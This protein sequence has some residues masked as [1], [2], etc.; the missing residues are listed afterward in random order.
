MFFIRVDICPFYES[1]G[2]EFCYNP[3]CTLMV[4]DA[5]FKRSWLTD[6]LQTSGAAGGLDLKVY[7]AP[8]GGTSGFLNMTL[9]TSDA[10]LPDAPAAAGSAGSLDLDRPRLARLTQSTLG[11]ADDSGSGGAVVGTDIY[12]V[13]LGATTNLAV[14]AA[15]LGLYARV[16]LKVE[17][18]DS[19]ATTPQA[20]TDN[21]VSEADV[22]LGA[23]PGVLCAGLAAGT[24]AIRISGKQVGCAKIPGNTPTCA[25]TSK[26][27]ASTSI[28]FYIVTAFDNASD[29]ST[30]A[31]ASLATTSNAGST[32][33]NLPSC[34]ELS[35][36]ATTEN[37]DSGGCCGSLDDRGFGGPEKLQELTAR[38]LMFSP[39]LWFAIVWAF[40]RG[41][42]QIKKRARLK[43]A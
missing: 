40:V 10:D 28:P 33:K 37:S 23:D 35:T 5:A 39:L 17:V 14:N 38:S 19:T 21:T 1:D 4:S 29:A 25:S 22:T 6:S 2:V 26:E 7:S 27:D 31:T 24:Y 16:R 12:K 32:Y 42:N 8:A 15:S 13:T 43:S 3:A 36:T 11:L 41:L 20:C 9:N 18:L 34:T 30:L